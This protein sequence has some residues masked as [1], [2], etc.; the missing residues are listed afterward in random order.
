MRH[1]REA[2]RRAG[3]RLGGV[4]AAGAVHLVHLFGL[5]VIGLHVFVADGPGGRDAVVVLNLAEVFLAQAVER[6][7]IHLGGA[8]D[9]VMETG[10]EGFPRLV[11]PGFLGNVAVLDENLFHVPILL[12]TFQPVAAL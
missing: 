3:G 6:R 5:G 12:F 11:V 10:L 8:A 9:E 4:F 2:T 7:A 1:R